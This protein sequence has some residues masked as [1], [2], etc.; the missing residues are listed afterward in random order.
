MMLITILKYSCLIVAFTLSVSTIYV[1]FYGKY[2]MVPDYII[3]AVIWLGYLALLLILSL[4]VYYFSKDTTLLH[5]LK[6]SIF[7]GMGVW[8]LFFVIT[9]YENHQSRLASEL[10]EQKEKAKIEAI[11]QAYKQNPQNPQNIIA[12]GMQALYDK[13][14]NYHQKYDKYPSDYIKEAID[15]HPL[16]LPAYKKMIELTQD[17]AYQSF[18][19]Y[20]GTEKGYSNDISLYPATE[21]RYAQKALRLDETGQLKLSQKDKSFFKKAIE[22][23]DN[24][25]EKLKTS[26]L[27]QKK[28]FAQYLNE[29]NQLT[30]D[31]PKDATAWAR[32][33]FIYYRYFSDYEHTYSDIREA[34]KL[35]PDIAYVQKIYGYY[36]EAIKKP[37]D[38]VKAYKRAIELDSTEADEL[39]YSIE[40][41]QEWIEWAGG[42]NP[43]LKSFYSD[44]YYRSYNQLYKSKT[45]REFKRHPNNPEILVDMGLIQDNNSEIEYYQKAIKQAP[46]YTKAYMYLTSAYYKNND[47]KEAKSIARDILDKSDNKELNISR[48]EYGFFSEFLKIMD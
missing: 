41:C 12:I 21:K 34:L 33:A 29:A 10:Q 18:Y 36:L 25:I 27:A 46:S 17:I 44:Y 11:F 26:K 14:D 13:E 9:Q 22:H 23:A 6:L 40:K 8:S 7:M 39:Q 5:I 47:F 30:V 37:K 24:W 48:V 43:Y 20:Y 35:N 31:N 45:K 1:I 38:A 42:A 15:N 28:N 3:L 16:F 2:G 19:D 32:R 4:A